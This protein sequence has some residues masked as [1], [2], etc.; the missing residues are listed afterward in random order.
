[1]KQVVFE[2]VSKAF[3]SKKI[4]ID[5]S[6]SLKQATCYALT[7][8]S[9]SGKTT[10]LRLIAGL[11]QPDSGRI[12]I[13][14]EKPVLSYAFQEPRLF[15]S[16]TVLENILLVSPEKD[17]FDLLNLLDLSQDANTLPS[18]LSGGMQK[19]AALARTLAKKADIYLLDEPT[20]GQDRQ[21]AEA[22]VEAIRAYTKDSICIIA[23]HDQTLFTSVADILLTLSE[24]RLNSFAL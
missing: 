4:L 7:G 15:P 9:G 20:G 14:P 17:P 2:S 1:M 16:L 6:M 21:H 10:I 3:G 18:Q 11:D 13:N 23:T 5:V 19:R 12:V 8:D 22:V 24:G